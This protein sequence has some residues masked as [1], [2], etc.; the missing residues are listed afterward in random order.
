MLEPVRPE[1]MLPDRALCLPT[2]SHFL[3]V[4]KTSLPLPL[5]LSLSHSLSPPPPPTHSLC[6]PLTMWL[7]LAGF[8]SPRKVSARAG[9]VF[10][11]TAQG[12]QRVL[13]RHTA[14]NTHRCI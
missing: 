7:P 8:R 3:I 4:K 11:S 10:D 2:F 9:R 12:R 14:E 5:S 6:T 13:R 1:A